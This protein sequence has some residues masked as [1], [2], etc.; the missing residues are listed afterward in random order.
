MVSLADRVWYIPRPFCDVAGA[1][2]ARVGSND[3]LF[4]GGFCILSTKD[5]SLG[6]AGELR[7]RVLAVLHCVLLQGLI[8]TRELL[9]TSERGPDGIPRVVQLPRPL[10]LDH[11]RP[12]V[13]TEQ[14]VRRAFEMSKRYLRVDPRRRSF[15]I[16]PAKYRRLW[17]GL[18]ALGRGMRES[19]LTTRIHDYVQAVEALLLL[20]RR[21]GEDR[22]IT[23]AMELTTGTASTRKS[24][25][26]AWDVRCAD[27][28][29]APVK[30]RVARARRIWDL[31]WKMENFAQQ[32]YV[33]LL[34]DGTLLRHFRTDAAIGDFWH[35]MTPN[36]RQRLW[37]SG[38]DIDA[39]GWL[40]RPQGGWELGRR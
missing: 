21:E 8:D 12:A 7:N 25:K 1:P 39:L 28:H 32:S 3:T 22:F 24:L 18:S 4:A 15:A 20:V 19:V 6:H 16:E 26:T 5:S 17:A 14:T 11:A 38:I 33:R 9:V 35:A 34:S 30:P 10:L 36:D 13:V 23:R 40:R 2:V 29:L 27:E 37:G 31:A